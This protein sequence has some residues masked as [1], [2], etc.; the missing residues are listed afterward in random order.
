MEA[1]DT[2]MTPAEIAR[3]LRE[4]SDD[5]WL[6]VIQDSHAY[7][8]KL[9]AEILYKA[10]IKEVVEWLT[11]NGTDF[12]TD[13]LER[14]SMWQAKLEE[15]GIIPEPIIDEAQELADLRHNASDDIIGR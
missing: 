1:K 13:Y 8:R 14:S 3:E 4:L 6:E 10:G 7:E 15:W 12:L 5:E 2:V 9:Q 11:A